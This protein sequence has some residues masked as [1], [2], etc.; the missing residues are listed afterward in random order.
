MQYCLRWAIRAVRENAE[1][2]ARML[3]ESM[4]A[5]G[6]HPTAATLHAMLACC[7][8]H[9][10]AAST[11]RCFHGRYG[12]KPDAF[13]MARV[14]RACRWKGETEAA[15][16]ELERARRAKLATAN[17][18]NALAEVYA[19]AGHRAAVRVQ[20][21]L[22][23]MTATGVAPNES[24]YVQ[25]LGACATEITATPSRAGALTELAESAFQSAAIEGL[26]VT[27]RV[28]DALCAVYAAARA[29]DR[30]DALERRMREDGYDPSQGFLE[31]Q[32][33]A[34]YEA[35]DGLEPE[36]D[37]EPEAAPAPA[38]PSPPAPAPALRHS[39]G[40]FGSAL[41]RFLGNDPTPCTDGE[42]DGAAT[43]AAADGAPRRQAAAPPKPQTLGAEMDE[44]LA[45]VGHAQRKNNPPQERHSGP[46]PEPK[47][48]WKVLSRH[49]ARSEVLR[50][51][52]EAC[53][54]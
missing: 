32:L 45:H 12:V 31:N 22:R 21:V 13:T 27:R 18:W 30:V 20:E 37:Q 4:V 48:H 26:L 16:Q 15:E 14:I 41:S 52:L 54:P 1:A 8:S 38:P 46:A 2:A 42:G 17:V 19:A 3:F 9:A 7:R 50:L 33:L 36:S 6:M 35:D 10:A 43:G 40:S 24:T 51:A 11:I 28:Y 34:Q 49:E 23:R 47:K 44:A 25:L 5:S 53:T 39:P 29:P